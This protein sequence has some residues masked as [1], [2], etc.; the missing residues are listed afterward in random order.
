MAD[1][2][3]KQKE[4]SRDAFLLE[5]QK[6]DLYGVTLQ[7]ADWDTCEESSNP[8]SCGLWLLFHTVTAAA[9]DEEAKDTI[10]GIGTYVEYFFACGECQKHFAHHVRQ[11]GQ[12]PMAGGN[13]EGM[14][15]LWRVHNAVN[16]RVLADQR[17]KHDFASIEAAMWPSKKACF[18]CKVQGR[19]QLY[20]TPTNRIPQPS[21]TGCCLG[22]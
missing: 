2:L 15:W 21:S 7:H 12:L 17:G 14:L 13:R 1:T 9:S 4:W 10:L 19:K 6:L 8:F 16:V 20:E 22:E 18:P 3:R 11:A 5:L